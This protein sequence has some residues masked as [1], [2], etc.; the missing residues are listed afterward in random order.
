MFAD[1]LI[2]TFRGWQ[3]RSRVNHELSAM[4]DRQLADIGIS[5]NDI[6]AVVSGRLVRRGSHPTR[7]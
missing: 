2:S 4:S 7:S 1:T 3:N 6:D 5:R